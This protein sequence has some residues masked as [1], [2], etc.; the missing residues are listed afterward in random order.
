MVICLCLHLAG[1]SQVNAHAPPNNN[2][3]PVS[4]ARAPYRSLWREKAAMLVLGAP[5]AKEQ[6]NWRLDNEIALQE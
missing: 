6:S 1:L 5:R 2:W 4:Q 3:K